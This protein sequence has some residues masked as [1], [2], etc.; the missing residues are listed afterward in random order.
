MNSN[1][2]LDSQT[3]VD[4]DKM[5]NVIFFNSLGFFYYLFLLSNIPTQYFNATGPQIGLVFSCNTIGILISSIIIGPLSDKYGKLKKK[6]VSLGSF[7]RAIALLLMYIAIIFNSLELF[8]IAIFFQGFVVMFFWTPLDTLI[9]EKSSREYRTKAF[10]KRTY[11]IG[12]G[13]LVGTLI[14]FCILGFSSYFYPQNIWLYYS[15]LVIFALCNIYAGIKFHQDVNENL[16]ITI[17]NHNE[18]NIEQNI[19]RRIVI[20]FVLLL[21][22]T[23]LIS[24]NNSFANPFLQAYIIDNIIQDPMIIMLIYF[25]AHIFGYILAPKLSDLSLRVNIYVSIALI[26]VFGAISTWIV[27]STT[28]GL[29]FSMVLLFDSLFVTV[30]NLISQTYSSEIS[31]NHRGKIF[32]AMSFVR[33][34]GA[35]VAPI[36]GGVVWEE[37]GHKTPFYITII[38]EILLIIPYILAIYFLIP[39]RN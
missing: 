12:I 3:T 31:P 17:Q 33:Y 35:I 13:S 28:S 37:I 36:I 27:I 21:I 5:I 20:G 24:I 30:E 29:I 4:F 34:G 15:P 38:A 32:S 25:P 7:G 14:V 8:I 6:L 10:A 39:R 22:V 18:T 11:L 9:S 2:Q 19:N 16:I 23:F 26:C 1:T